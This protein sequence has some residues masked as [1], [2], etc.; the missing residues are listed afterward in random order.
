[1]SGQES[2]LTSFVAQQVSTLQG[3]QLTRKHR[4]AKRVTYQTPFEVSD[5]DMKDNESVAF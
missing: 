4:A 2:G 5:I 1:M 3:K